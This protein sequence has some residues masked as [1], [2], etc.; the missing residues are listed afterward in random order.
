MW[1]AEQASID[2]VWVKIKTC[3]V[4]ALVQN[5]RGQTVTKSSEK[6]TIPIM[7]A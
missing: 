3:Q 2:E 4:E 7:M 5:R 6:I 1:A